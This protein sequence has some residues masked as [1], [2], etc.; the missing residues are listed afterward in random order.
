MTII[1][2]ELGFKLHVGNVVHRGWAGAM[3]G[4]SRR[5]C[6]HGPGASLRAYRVHRL[7]RPVLSQG[8]WVSSCGKRERVKKCI[9]QNWAVIAHV[10]DWIS[11]FDRGLRTLTVVHQAVRPHPAAA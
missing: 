7:A 2:V 5:Y 4:G 8:H 1:I 11:G 3:C 6:G 10:M 9:E